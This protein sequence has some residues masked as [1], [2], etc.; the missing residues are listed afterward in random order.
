MII[1]HHPL[2]WYS[3]PPL[4]KQ[5]ID[6]VLEFG[7]AYGPGGNALKDKA[8]FNVLT[9]GGTRE[10]YQLSG[11]NRFTLRTFLTPFEQTASLCK[12]IYLPPFAIQGTRRL[13]EEQLEHFGKQYQ[14]IL[15]SFVE[16]T[17]P[18][19]ELKKLEYFNDWSTLPTLL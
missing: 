7:W 14:F 17:M 12:M 2:F 4:L 6:V 9:S 5:W 8:I 16:T 3:A 11:N 10:V 15:T 13:S 1:W 19:E 18:L